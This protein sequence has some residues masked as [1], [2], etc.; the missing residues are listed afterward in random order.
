[1]QVLKVKLVLI[2]F[3]AANALP[4]KLSFQ[5]LTYFFL[6]RGVGGVPLCLEVQRLANIRYLVCIIYFVLVP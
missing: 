1:M 2:Y 3:Y 4:T 6:K 5:N